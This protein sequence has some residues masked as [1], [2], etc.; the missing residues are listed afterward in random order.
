MN[1]LYRLFKSVRLAVV[2]ILVITALSLL[3]TLVPQGK[4]SAYYQRHFS[5]VVFRLIDW[6]QFDRFFSSPLF[7]IPVALFTVNLA[8]CAVDRFFRRARSKAPKRFGPDLIHIGLLL[9]IAASLVTALSR[10]EKDYTL[11]PGSEAILQNTKYTLS[12][13][14][15]EFLRYETGSPKAWISTVSVAKDGKT[16]IASFPIEV[17]HPLRLKGVTVYQNAWVSEA[18]LALP[19]GTEGTIRAGEVFKDGSSYWYF[20]D[21][22]KDGTTLKALFQEYRGHTI[23]SM[24]KAGPSDA[25]GSYTVKEV[26]QSTVL[27]AVSDPGYLPVIIALAIAVLGLALT[28]IQKRREEKT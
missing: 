24:R 14:S 27:R 10:K 15:F 16:D 2:L 22:V 7:L 25:V 1:A 21:I 26:N 19:D 12:L 4:D 8:V 5:S 3:A 6:F 23:V 20:A 17:N 18:T 11:A 13:K 28:F 9:L